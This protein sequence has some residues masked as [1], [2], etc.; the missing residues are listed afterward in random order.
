MKRKSTVHL[1]NQCC[2]FYFCVTSEWLYGKAW[3]GKHYG[4]YNT[5]LEPRLSTLRT[6]MIYF[7]YIYASN[8]EKIIFKYY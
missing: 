4:N 8:L 7:T 2:Q 6:H 1:G 3:L 5:E